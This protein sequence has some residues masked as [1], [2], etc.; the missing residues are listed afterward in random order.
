MSGI[1]VELCAQFFKRD[2]VNQI[3]KDAKQNHWVYRMPKSWIPYLQLSRLDR[4]IGI[5]LLALPGWIALAFAGLSN[6]LAWTDLKW[7]ALIL[8]GAIAMRG[9]GC[10]YNDIVD[11]DLDAQVERTA[12]RPIP[13]GTVSIKQAWIWLLVQCLVGLGV[14]L[15]L[16]RLAQIIALCS[17]PLVAAYPFMKRITWWPQVWLG[18]TFNWAALVAYAAKTGEI[19]PA[20]A[21]LYLGLIFWTVGYDTIYAC[22]DIE[23]DAFVGIKSTARRFGKHIR[24]GVGLSYIICLLCIAFSIS[25]LNYGIWSDITIHCGNETNR[26]FEWISFLKSYPSNLIPLLVGA[27][28]IHLMWQVVAFSP[29]NSLKSLKLFK[30]NSL[31]GLLLLATFILIPFFNMG[32]GTFVSDAGSCMTVR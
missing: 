29:N 26:S 13:A 1:Y 16:P 30:S 25:L 24:F 7:A 15:C 21:A 28:T 3:I 5:W 9:A 31:A 14:L 6:G 17:I 19:S 22:Q 20:A 2:C 4:P 23:D 12:L 10:T 8:I 27:F 11:K 18:L 32:V